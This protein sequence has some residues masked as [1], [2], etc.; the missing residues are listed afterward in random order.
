MR[1]SMAVKENQCVNVQWAAIRD[2]ETLSK[3]C[4]I[5]FYFKPHFQPKL[6]IIGYM[7]QDL[8]NFT[9]IICH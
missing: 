2:K 9:A 7:K 5:L 8:N 4:W 6:F 1:I 3:H